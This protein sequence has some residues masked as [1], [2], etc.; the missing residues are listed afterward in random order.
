MADPVSAGYDKFGAEAYDA[1]INFVGVGDPARAATMGA[2]IL[3]ITQKYDALAIAYVKVN[4]EVRYVFLS[5]GAVYGTTFLKP[6]DQDTPAVVPVNH[7]G[8]ENYY[9]VAKL[10][11]EANHRALS[12]LPIVDIRIF[13]Y[14][15]RTS[16]IAA[17]FFVSDM[18]RAIRDGREFETGS[19]TMHRDYLVPS[20]FFSLVDCILRGPLANMA[21]DAYTRAPVEKFELLDAM[22]RTFGLQY[23]TTPSPSVVNATGVKTFYYSQN[24]KAEQFGYQPRQTSLEGVLA[25]SKAILN[26]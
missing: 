4:P 17:R 16:D 26:R 10:Y 7:L 3:E 9:S 8:A 20:D 25:E 22:E 11:A 18:L 12:P 23:R 24:R 14:F 15:S 6:V 19:A 2:S 5:S 21:V 1:V 13:N